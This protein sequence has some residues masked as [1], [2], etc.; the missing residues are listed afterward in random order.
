MHEKQNTVVSISKL[1]MQCEQSELE[2]FAYRDSIFSIEFSK[3]VKDSGPITSKERHNRDKIMNDFK[4]DIELGDI[5]KITISDS[6]QNREEIVTV[7][8]PFVGTVI[9]SN[10]IKQADDEISINKGEV[11]CSIEAMKIYNEIK[12][13]ATGTIVQILVDDCCLVE[14]GQPIF[15]IRVDKDA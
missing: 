12:A 15:K 10:H 7:V 9:L 3:A 14:F 4:L 6:L 13:P 5:E 1:I 2:S 8:S 11:I